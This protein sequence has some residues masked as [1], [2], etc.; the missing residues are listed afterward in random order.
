M[1]YWQKDR[2]Y[3]KYS[4]ENG[5]FRYVVTVDGEDVEVTPEVYEAYAQADRRERYGYERD[6]GVLLSLDRLEEDGMQLTWLTDQ[7][8]ESAEDTAIQETMIA[9]MMEALD[10]LEPEE[11]ELI[12]LLFFE[13]VSI[14]ELARR[15]GMHLHAIQYRRDKVLEKLRIFLSK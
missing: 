1:K 8:V 15:A 6:E 9:R 7:N 10:K 4:D 12:E 3:R 13:G 5:T 11:R 14:R 2:N